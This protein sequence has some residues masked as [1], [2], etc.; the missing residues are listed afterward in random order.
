MQAGEQFLLSCAILPENATNQ[1]ISWASSN[2]AVVTAAGGQLTALKKG[3]ATITVT[4]ED[5]KRK[6]ICKVTVR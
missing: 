5:G 6:A 1:N 2:S 4:S 3:S